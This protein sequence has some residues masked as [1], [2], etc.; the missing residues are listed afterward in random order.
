MHP[1]PARSPF[2]SAMPRICVIGG[3]GFVGRH[4]VEL[5]VRERHTVIVPSRRRERS[6]HLASMP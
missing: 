6:K 2:P 5:L 4:I 1:A 3:S